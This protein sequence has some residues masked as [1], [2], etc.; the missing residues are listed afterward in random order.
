MKGGR[1]GVGRV[2]ITVSIG[3]CGLSGWAVSSTCPLPAHCA[4]LGFFLRGL[5]GRVALVSVSV[6]VSL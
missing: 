6:C 1:E 4:W 5:S 2:V 3:L